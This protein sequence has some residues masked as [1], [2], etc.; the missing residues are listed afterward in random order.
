[1][2]VIAWLLRRDLNVVLPTALAISLFLI[3]DS[4]GKRPWPVAAFPAVVAMAV[5]IAYDF[6]QPRTP[7]SSMRSAEAAWSAASAVV[8]VAVSVLL[9]EAVIMLL[10]PEWSLPRRAMTVGLPLFCGLLFLLRPR[11]LSLVLWNSFALLTL[12]ALLLFG[13]LNSAGERPWLVAALPTFVSMGL[14]GAGDLYHRLTLTPTA[15]VTAVRKASG[16][17]AVVAVAVVLCEVLVRVLAP[18][19]LLPPQALIVGLPVF[20]TVLF[21]LRKAAPPAPARTASPAIAPVGAGSMQAALDRALERELRRGALAPGS[22]F[23]V[24]VGVLRGDV[25]CVFSYGAARPDSIFEIGSVSKTFT[26]L[27]LAQMIE[28]GRVRLDQPVRELLPAATVEKPPRREISLLDLVTHHSGLPRLPYNLRPA[29][30]RNPYVDYRAVDLYRFLAQHGVD[31]PAEASY[32]YSNVGSGL[33]GQAL[34]H[35]AGISFEELL[36]R[37]VTMPLGLKDTVMSLTP[38]QHSRFIPGYTLAHHQAPGWD[39]DSLAGAGALRSTAGDI[40]TYLEAQLHPRELARTLSSTVPAAGTLPQAIERSHELREAADPGMHIAMGWLQMDA[41]GTYW[42]SGATGGHC[43][44]VF[45]NPQE[46]CAGVVLANITTSRRGS[47]AD[48][49]AQHIGNRFAG[50]PAIRL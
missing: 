7:I 19:W 32:L 23:G 21:I 35:R 30:A 6:Y 25:R 34:A 29:D 18:E 13:I 45:F 4:V 37:E 33:L 15:F 41:T 49:I 28:Q 1:M 39:W 44:F 5:M 9:C 31:R 22:P 16:D 46:D 10:A 40:L 17:V 38:E 20:C 26:G 12:L 48:L 27:I 43:S 11:V 42:H 36:E 47:L 2:F 14:L 8:I 24:T 3:L 50:K